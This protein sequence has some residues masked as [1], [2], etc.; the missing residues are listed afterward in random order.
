MTD[1]LNLLDLLL[2]GNEYCSTTSNINK[3]LEDPKNYYIEHDIQ[4]C[5]AP[6]KYFEAHQ[7]LLYTVDSDGQKECILEKS[8]KN[9]FSVR[10]IEFINTLLIDKNS[11]SEIESN[12][13][14]LS[15]KHSNKLESEILKYKDQSIFA[16]LES[17]ILKAFA[18]NKT[19]IFGKDLLDFYKNELSKSTTPQSY[20]KSIIE[21]FTMQAVYH[22]EGDEYFK[23]VVDYAKEGIARRGQ[24]LGNLINEYKE[25]S[26]SRDYS[27]VIYEDFIELAKWL[28]SEEGRDGRGYLGDT[29]KFISDGVSNGKYYLASNAKEILELIYRGGVSL[30]DNIKSEY[31]TRFSEDATKYGN[32][33]E[34]IIENEISIS[35]K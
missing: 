22:D 27:E 23:I 11:I 33:I 4:Q 24:Y 13:I 18:L 30:S 5:S 31:C 8:Y 12:I 26:K 15:L 16:K 3:C 28:S 25:L 9:G 10:D 35:K 6:N 17:I 32:I 19:Y 34:V 21:L 2:S 20:K 1:S 29:V 7:E 14:N